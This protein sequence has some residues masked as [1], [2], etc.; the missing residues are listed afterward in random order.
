MKVL[1]IEDQSD[2]REFQR[3]VVERMG[4]EAVLAQT[5]DE[6]RQLLPVD[7]VLVDFSLRGTDGIEVLQAI[8]ASQPE[9]DV[10]FVTA[11]TAARDLERIKA[12][13]ARIVRKP[14]SIEELTSALDGERGGL[15]ARTS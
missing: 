10:V 14:H 5:G 2:I 1:I 15:D 8:R 3:Y 11:T 7:I 4:H 13:G 6:A 12:T 9:V